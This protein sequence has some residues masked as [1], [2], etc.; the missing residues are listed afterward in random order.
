MVQKVLKKKKLKLIKFKYK[1]LRLLKTEKKFIIRKYKRFRIRD[2]FEKILMYQFYK[3]FKY[4]LYYIKP[5]FSI[6]VFNKETVKDFQVYT[7]FDLLRNYSNYLFFQKLVNLVMYKGKKGLAESLV[8][9]TLEILKNEFKILNPFYK[10]K[11]II[12][13]NLVP[14]I[15]PKKLI[16]KIKVKNKKK[17]G[18][19]TIDKIKYLGKHL[20]L[21]FRL[22]YT[23]K[24]IIKGARN[25]TSSFAYS[26]VA[27]ILNCFKSQ[28]LLFTY[29]LDTI[30]LIKEHRLY[31]FT[32]N[33]HIN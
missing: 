12:Y 21:H 14:F 27:E 16:T 9:K 26:L 1:K 13:K 6:R 5:N 11:F 7:I 23:I 4:Y 17:K 25:M 18:F 30:R 24:L 20:R 8:L 10:L 33:P 31:T 29:N 15:Q 3:N 32:K 19:E 28:G 22:N 2:N